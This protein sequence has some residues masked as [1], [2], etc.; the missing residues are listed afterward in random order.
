MSVVGSCYPGLCAYPQPS[1]GTPRPH[2]HWGASAGPSPYPS[3]CRSLSQKGAHWEASEATV[4]APTAC[5]LCSQRQRVCGLGPC[6]GKKHPFWCVSWAA[7]HGRCPCCLPWAGSSPGTTS[8]RLPI[9]GQGIP[10][11]AHRQGCECIPPSAAPAPATAPHVPSSGSATRTPDPGEERPGS[12][13]R[14]CCV[15]PARCGPAC[16]FLP[17]GPLRHE[18]LGTGWGFAGGTGWG[19]AGWGRQANPFPTR[20]WPPSRR[21]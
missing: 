3:L 21:D 13:G 10:S 19:S 15:S 20:S 7:S 11:G 2:R 6:G 16:S 5:L 9:M 18:H 14:L 12:G 17:P 1:Q 8:L 4:Q